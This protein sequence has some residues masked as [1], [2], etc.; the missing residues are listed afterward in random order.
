MSSPHG[1]TIACPMAAAIDGGRLKSIRY[2]LK[3]L[4]KSLDCAFLSCCLCSRTR[5]VRNLFVDRTNRLC[6]ANDIIERLDSS[7]FGT[8]RW[9]FRS[10]FHVSLGEC[11][12]LYIDDIGINRADCHGMAF[13]NGF[14]PK[15]DNF[16]DNLLIDFLQIH[17][18][19][20]YCKLMNRNLSS[21]SATVLCNLSC[22]H[23]V[24]KARVHTNQVLNAISFCCRN[25]FGGEIRVN[26]PTCMFD[27]H[28]FSQIK[29]VLR[30]IRTRNN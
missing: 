10:N 9:R 24:W 28:L 25:S 7:F 26:T 30:H 13:R 23:L 19:I 12:C 20:L 22:D 4:I 17:F 14:S 8:K 3:H 11:L 5:H 18:L 29:H 1:D 6:Q 16:P 15:I 21:I 27:I 2:V